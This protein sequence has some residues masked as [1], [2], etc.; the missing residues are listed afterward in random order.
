MFYVVPFTGSTSV[1]EYVAKAVKVVEARGH[2]YVVTPAATVFEAESVAEALE[3]V[4]QAIEAVKK[5][6]ARRVIAEIKIDERLD[7]PL[8]LE[9]MP[10]RVL[11]ALERLRK[12]EG[13][14]SGSVPR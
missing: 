12:E 4:A 11:E 2:K 3:T 10:K 8:R 14:H 1:S 13:Q 9:E 6:G 5:A 7:K